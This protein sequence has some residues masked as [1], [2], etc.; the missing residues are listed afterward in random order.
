VGHASTP[1]AG[2]QT[3]PCGTVVSIGVSIDGTRLLGLVESRCGAALGLHEHRINVVHVV[4][5]RG[6]ISN[7][8]R[9]AL[10]APIHT[11]RGR[12][13]RGIEHGRRGRQA[14][15]TSRHLVWND[16]D[17]VSGNHISMRS[18]CSLV[19]DRQRRVHHLRA[20]RPRERLSNLPAGATVESSSAIAKTT[21]S[22]KLTRQGTC[23]SR[24]QH[25]RRWGRAPRVAMGRGMSAATSAG[26]TANKNRLKRFIVRYSPDAN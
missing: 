11:C 26:T 25:V 6:I 22:S 14:A 23:S 20:C 5:L 15:V 18:G 17:E 3:R 24:V 19:V 12:A 2:L 4:P 9:E 16:V 10:V 1:A 7:D 8:P 13:R 21:D